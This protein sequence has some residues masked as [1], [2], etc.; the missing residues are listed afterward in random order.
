VRQGTFASVSLSWVWK[1]WREVSY[2]TRGNSR[3]GGAVSSGL[4][5]DDCRTGEGDSELD[6]LH[7]VFSS[8]N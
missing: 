7:D 4:S 3:R 6:E 1:E 5:S 2:T 8:T